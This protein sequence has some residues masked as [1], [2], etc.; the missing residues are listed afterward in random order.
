MEPH[1]VKEEAFALPP[2]SM[3]AA[4]SRGERVTGAGQV[5]AM[6]EKLRAELPALHEEHR[7]FV[8]LLEQ[9]LV[10]TRDSGHADYAEF[11]YNLILHAKIEE[12]IMYPAALLVGDFLRMRETV[13]V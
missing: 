7:M 10:V 11:V 9:L 12:E 4:L 1:F 6:T 2:L 13:P 3:L 8:R 5:L